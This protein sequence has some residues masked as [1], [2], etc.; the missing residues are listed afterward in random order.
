[1]VDEECRSESI[2]SVIEVEQGTVIDQKRWRYV[3]LGL[4]EL[5]ISTRDVKKILSKNPLFIYCS[6]I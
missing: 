4:D 5:M 1:V 6:W 3:P 2:L